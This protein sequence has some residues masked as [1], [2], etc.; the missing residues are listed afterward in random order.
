[1][2]THARLVIVGAGIVGASAA[3]HLTQL[4][5]RD[6]LVLDK[7]DLFENDGSTSHAPGGVVALS[8]SKLLTQ[9]A[10][11]SSDLFG[12]LKPYREDRNTYNAVGGLEVAISAER[13][14]DLKRL[15][16]E[17]KSFHA[18]SHLLTP[19]ETQAKAPFVNPDALVG[20]LFVPKGAIVAGSHVTAALAR[21]A[22]ATGGARFIANTGVTDIE[23]VNGQVRA[24][25]TNNPDLP[26]IDCEQV[27]LCTNIWGPLLGD[28]LGVR[29]PL[30]AFEHQYVVTE[31]LA[32]LSHF[33]RGNKNHEMTWPTLRE[34]DSAMYYRHH[35]DS[36][37]IGSY[38][39]KPR[40][41]Q[42]RQIGK[43]AMH[44]FTPE[45]FSSA[46][47]QAQRIVPILQGA[48]FQRAFN[49]MFAFSVD[50]YPII[51]ES[52]IRGLWTAVASWITHSGGVGK[53]VAEWMTHGQAEWD[54]RQCHIQRFQPHQTTASF[55]EVVTKKNYREVYDIIHPA[56]PITEPRNVR[57]TPFHPRLQEL[58]ASFTAFAGMELPN[59]FESNSRLLEQ[60]DERIPWRTGWAAEWWSRIQGAE[61]LATRE[62]VALFD[63]SGLSIIEVSGSGACG[64][65]NYLCS[66]QCNKPAGSVIYTSWL[67]PTGGVRRDL[68]VTRL[69]D[70]RFWM[71][72]GEGTLPQDLD[73][74]GRVADAP[75][76][77]VI[78]DVSAAWSA[79]GL[80]GP[81][82]RRV[83]EKATNAD[84]S[85]EAFPY[86]S[87]QWI[88][89]G[90][91]RVLA[92][93][94]SYAGELGW[95]LHIPTESSLPVWD[96][97]WEA[98]REFEMAAAGIGAFDSLRLEKGYRL[99]GGDVHTE[100]NA[101]EAGLGWTVRLSKPDFIGKA[102]GVELKKKP[103]KKK[104][105]CLTFDDPAGVALGYEPILAGEECVGYIT[106]SNYGYS[107]GQQIAYGYLPIEQ[108]A[109]G[110]QLAVEFLGQRF[111]VTV[112][113]EPLWDGEMARLKG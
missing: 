99:W 64:F 112:R 12:S 104:L 68:T 34:L 89:I 63:L 25:L 72:V 15:H 97:L 48:K 45:D 98:G 102:A 70:D 80:W 40:A 16:G 47:A 90:S 28:K 55:T 110:T 100:Y 67:T 44:D 86:F 78:A 109:P 21:D 113:D 61:H 8:H 75:G 11:Y 43:T 108:A 85:N 35:W 51:G 76:T 49:G 42:P 65:V 66:N 22:E 27:L 23:V 33:D 79:L 74:V 13:W 20:S 59:W 82:A 19:A 36:F 14:Q 107:I 54:M 29:L 71:F 52:H 57:L 69:A 32:A 93:R 41:I 96:R 31:P 6:I 2:Q 39:H 101:Y 24:V 88:E 18:E 83:L 10:L 46:W 30:L 91:A 5:W 26:R 77:V 17:A 53:S 62:N 1:M 94:I 95:E 92:L 81:N 4:G 56:Q 9:M 84:V 105:C 58:E 3:Y 73:W 38:W 7:G 103:L 60:Y 37:G 111:A 106:T 87:A 50:G